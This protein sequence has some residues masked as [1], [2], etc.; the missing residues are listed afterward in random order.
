MWHGHLPCATAAVFALEEED[1][2][3]EEVKAP[4]KDSKAKKDDAPVEIE[5][6]EEE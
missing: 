5:L 3:Q 4:S 2:A 6:T 1:E